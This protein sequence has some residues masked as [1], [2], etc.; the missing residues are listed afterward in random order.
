[1]AELISLEEAFDDIDRLCTPEVAD[2]FYVLLEEL[3]NDSDLL[4]ILFLPT[5]HYQYTPPFEVKNY[6]A[7]QNQGKNFLILKVRNEQG[8]LLDYRLLLGYHSQIETYYV[9]TLMDRDIDYDLNHPDIRIA[10]ER[11]EQCGIPS[12]PRRR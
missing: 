9:L 11:Y 12:Y 3:E 1:M 7:M 10:I 5:N 4:E 8:T 6:V 2:L